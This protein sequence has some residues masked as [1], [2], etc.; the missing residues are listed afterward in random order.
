VRSLGLVKGG[1][2]NSITLSKLNSAA[3]RPSFF[4]KLLRLA[5]LARSRAAILLPHLVN[6]TILIP[7]LRHV[8]S[9]F[10]QS[11]DCS[12]SHATCSCVS[13]LFFSE[14]MLLPKVDRAKVFLNVQDFG[15]GHNL[16][17]VK[18]LCSLISIRAR[19]RTYFLNSSTRKSIST[20]TRI[21]ILRFDGKMIENGLDAPAV[22]FMI[23][24]SVPCLSS[25]STKKR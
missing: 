10:V 1:A 4:L 9:T 6:V 18:E 22:R 11:F 16:S 5:Q 24:T 8:S 17:G 2:H 21:G 25:A 14:C 23:S 15:V 20:R 19:A 13:A 12:N 7:V 3:E